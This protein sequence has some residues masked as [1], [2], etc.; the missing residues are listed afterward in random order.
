MTHARAIEL[1]YEIYE[2]WYILFGYISAELGI[3]LSW[4]GKPDAAP[5]Y[6]N[7]IQVP[8]SRFSYPHL[9]TLY[10][11]TEMNTGVKFCFLYLLDMSDARCLATLYRFAGKT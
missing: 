10:H 6:A 5:T 2:P 4:L 11:G 3:S 7:R 8:G 9:W 1:L